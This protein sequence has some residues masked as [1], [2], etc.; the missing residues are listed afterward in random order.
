VRANKDVMQDQLLISIKG[1]EYWL[2][3]PAGPT[4][5]FICNGAGPYQEDPEGSNRV[6]SIPISPDHVVVGSLAMCAYWELML[7]STSQFPAS[8]LFI[9][10]LRAEARELAWSLD[11]KNRG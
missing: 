6:P 8:H 7:L 2:L 10:R 5:T 9:G 4:R 11:E 1:T 3:A